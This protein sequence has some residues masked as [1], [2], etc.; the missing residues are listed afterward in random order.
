MSNAKKI[1]TE[2]AELPPDV[3]FAEAR[4][5]RAEVSSESPFSYAMEYVAGL[6]VIV[7]FGLMVVIPVSTRLETDLDQRAPLLFQ[8]RIHTARALRGS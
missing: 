8:R 1:W 6:F 4:H 2:T 3:S 7:V 5:P